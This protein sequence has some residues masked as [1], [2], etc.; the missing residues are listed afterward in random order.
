MTIWLSC[1][2]RSNVPQMGL[3][4]GMGFMRI[5]RPHAYWKKSWHGSTV[6]SMA[7]II[8]ADA[9]TQAA[10]V[11]EPH[12]SSVFPAGRIGNQITIK[13][14]K[15]VI[16]QVHKT[17]RRPVVKRLCLY[18]SREIMPV[19]FRTKT[20]HPYDRDCTLNIK[21]ILNI[22]WNPLSVLVYI[23]RTKLFRVS[24]EKVVVIR[25]TWWGVETTCHFANGIIV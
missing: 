6:V 18:V 2:R 12:P 16:I 20:Q 10:L 5:Q 13:H 3:P 24:S 19:S 7:D 1:Q 11:H 9:L 21:Y 8:N 22:K 17:L 25:L 23:W 4:A 14:K 15:M